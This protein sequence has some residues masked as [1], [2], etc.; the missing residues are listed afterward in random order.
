MD[1]WIE[2]VTRDN[3]EEIKDSFTQYIKV[4]TYKMKNGF[5]K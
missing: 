4:T 5:T 3:N 2:P 1:R